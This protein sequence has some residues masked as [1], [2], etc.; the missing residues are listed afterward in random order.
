MPTTSSSVLAQVVHAPRKAEAIRRLEAL[1]AVVG[2]SAQVDDIV[3]ALQAD[4]TLNPADW[5]AEVLAVVRIVLGDPIP[6][7]VEP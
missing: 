4:N 5:R 7:R 2:A 1:A 6:A 3:A